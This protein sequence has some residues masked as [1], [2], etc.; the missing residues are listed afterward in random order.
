[1]KNDLLEEQFEDVV[2]DAIENE[3]RSNARKNYEYIGVT[4][5]VSCL[6][7]SYFNRKYPDTVP[8][9]ST[10]AL[11][12]KYLHDIIENHFMRVF[13]DYIVEK[14]VTFYDGILSGTVDLL[15][16]SKDC[17]ERIVIDIKTASRIPDKPYESHTLQVNAYLHLANATEGYIIYVD[18]RYAKNVL[19]ND[20][21]VKAFKLLF[22]SSVDCKWY[23]KNRRLYDNLKERALILKRCL[24]TN[25]PPRYEWTE[26]CAYCEHAKR[27]FE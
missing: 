13:K 8:S 24:D 12:G 14:E 15:L 1:M 19:T 7:R 11:I 4:E 5:V 10:S 3:Y 9:W 26:N 16:I 27:C 17:D 23:T 20:K 21:F 2:I 25:T 22:Y 18:K 6:R